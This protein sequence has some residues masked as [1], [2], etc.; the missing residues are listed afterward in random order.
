[1]KNNYVYD[2]LQV[3]ILSPHRKENKEIGKNTDEYGVRFEGK[4]NDK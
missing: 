2:T 4:D 3:H 1:M